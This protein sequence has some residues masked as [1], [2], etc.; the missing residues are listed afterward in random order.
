MKPWTRDNMPCEECEANRKAIAASLMEY[1]RIFW[2]YGQIIPS[3]DRHKLA[4]LLGQL[5]DSGETQ[6][7]RNEIVDL[8]A[9]HEVQMIFRSKHKEI[10]Y[11]PY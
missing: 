3:E 2:H 8:L 11:V 4:Q 9:K 5:A 6:R 7:V 10:P 1:A